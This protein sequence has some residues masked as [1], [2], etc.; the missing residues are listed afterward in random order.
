MKL[1]WTA[2][3]GLAFSAGIHM[4]AQTAAEMQPVSVTTRGQS[5]PNKLIPPN[6]ALDK[7]P[8]NYVLGPDDQITI[9]VL[10]AEEISD[11]PVQISSDGF[12]TIPLVGR[13]Q[14]GGLTVSQFEAV[15]RARLKTFIKDPQVSVMITD[16]RSEPVSVVGAVNTAGVV[17]LRGKRTL[18]EVISLAGGLRPDAG[19]TVTITRE[20]N[21]GAIPLAGAYVDPTGRF[22]VAQVN[23]LKITEAKNPEE[24]IVIQPD[25]VI[26]VSR[27]QMVYVVGEVGKPGGFILNDRD[28]LST[29]QALSLAGGLNKDAAPKRAKVLRT[30]DGKQDRVEV[31]ANL[32]SI[33]DGRSPDIE[34]HA[35]D[36]LFIPNSAP[37]SAGA[38]LF[39]AAINAGTGIAI[40][41]IP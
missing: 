15:L 7:H 26:A 32:R 34:L 39:E 1:I 35:D 22:S 41:R 23:L 25:D 37:K 27:A 20:L 16:Y 28:T 9:R 12:V 19:N 17:Q 5:D 33:M 36:I 2:V 40:W 6:P 24:N 11:K 29:L 10:E 38:R 30:I 21:R 3:I 4:L 8:V 31:A 14:A 13:I 18:I